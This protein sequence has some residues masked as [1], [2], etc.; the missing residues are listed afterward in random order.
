[1][2]TPRERLYKAIAAG[3]EARKIADEAQRNLDA[4]NIWPF[5]PRPRFAPTPAPVHMNGVPAARVPKFRY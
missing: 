5:L 3:K 4:E 2:E 1:M